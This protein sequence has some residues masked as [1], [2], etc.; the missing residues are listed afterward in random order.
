MQFIVV[1][2]G[3]RSGYYTQ[4][5]VGTKNGVFRGSARYSA[6]VPKG[7]LLEVAVTST[8]AGPDLNIYGADIKLWQ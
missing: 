6:P 5:I 7:A 1:T 2:K 4:Q 8:V 3:R